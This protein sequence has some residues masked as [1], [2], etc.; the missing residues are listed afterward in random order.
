M[1]E[2]FKNT[3]R[4]I[5]GMR[6]TKLTPIGGRE[7]TN[8]YDQIR[9]RFD[10]WHKS[11]QGIEQALKTGGVTQS[12]LHYYH[13]RCHEMKTEM[14]IARESLKRVRQNGEHFT[15]GSML[16]MLICNLALLN[17]RIKEAER[18]IN[19]ALKAIAKPRGRRP[20]VFE[21]ERPPIDALEGRPLVAVE[22]TMFGQADLEELPIEAAVPRGDVIPE[23]SVPDRSLRERDDFGIR[24][25][26]FDS[27]AE[28][29]RKRRKLDL[30]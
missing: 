18:V 6:I 17:E 9:R 19:A 11:L 26:N 2:I 25:L 15:K 10:A 13:R 29:L 4:R 22:P 28:P 16:W 27:Q 21:I 14:N 5:P 8:Y 12:N 23:A 24:E 20:R 3:F 30:E 1:S 7:K